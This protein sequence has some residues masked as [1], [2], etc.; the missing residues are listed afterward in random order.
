MHPQEKR[1]VPRMSLAEVPARSLRL[2]V[3]NEPLA[4][5][6]LRDI[7]SSGVSFELGKSLPVSAKVAL[8]FDD[9]H[10]DLQVN[11]RV[12]WCKPALTP[13]GRGHSAAAYVA[14]VELLSPMMLYAVLPHA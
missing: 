9:A 1:L 13:D 2:M 8:R 5:A 7:S 3:D 6:V 12:A 4:I 11:G 14:G 10:I